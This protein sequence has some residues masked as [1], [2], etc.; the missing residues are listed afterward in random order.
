M[1]KLLQGSGKMRTL[2][3]AKKCIGKSA[4]RKDINR[5][6]HDLEKSGFVSVMY[7]NE[8]NKSDPVWSA[9][10]KATEITGISLFYI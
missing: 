7:R 10:P 4:T 9:L 8:A 5:Y 2:D 1:L 6:L 3:V